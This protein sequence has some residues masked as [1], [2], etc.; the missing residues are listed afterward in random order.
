MKINT[1]D[2]VPK[3]VFFEYFV[4]E[5]HG[6]SVGLNKHDSHILFERKKVVLTGVPGAFT[7]TCSEKHLPDFIEKENEVRALGID[8]IFFMAVNDPFV[9]A[10]WGKYYNKPDSIRMIGDPDGSFT[11]EVGLDIDLSVAGLGLRSK[12]FT[13]VI[14]ENI[15]TYIKVEDAPP[16]YERSSASMLIE[17]LKSGPG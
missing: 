5:A 9:M 7:P 2:K 3:S 15:M 8:E 11:K 12:R 4:S 13:A 17:S 6:C 1:K 16:D 14:E 10:Y